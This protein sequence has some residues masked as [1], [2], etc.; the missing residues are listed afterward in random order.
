MPYP[1]FN[2][3]R[4]DESVVTDTVYSDAST[5]DNGCKQAQIFVGA[6]IMLTYVYGMKTSSQCINTLEDRIRNRGVMSQLISGSAK[7]EINKQVLDILRALC[8]G[9]WQSEP[10]QQHQNPTE[11]RYKPVKR[12]MNTLLDQSGSPVYTW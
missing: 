10:H 3:K 8:I 7:I 4:R 2:V 11:R 12:M 1:A 9:D 5:I 6:K